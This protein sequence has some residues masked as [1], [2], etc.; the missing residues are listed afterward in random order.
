MNNLTKYYGVDVSKSYLDV[1]GLDKPCRFPNTPEGCAQLFAAL[2][3]HAHLVCEASG[4]YERILCA[5][6]W[7]AARPI[8][9]VG[10][11]RVR[12]FARSLGLL[13]KTDRLDAAL[14]TRYAIERKPVPVGPPDEVI[15]RLRSYLRAREHVLE[16][17]RHE[18]NHREHLADTPLLREQSDTRLKL[19]DGQIDALE[20]AVTE[21]GASKP[22]L[23]VCAARLQE[24]RGVGKITA[25]T[26]CA[27]LP[28]LGE[29]K[30]GQAAAL[31]G[32]APFARDSG[33]RNGRRFI[34]RGRSTLRRVLHMAAITASVHNPRLRE[35]YLH[36][37]KRGKP[38]KVALVALAR[39][40][41]EFLN[42]IVK[43][44]N[45][46]LDI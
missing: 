22:A 27:D 33:D 15:E 30:P 24:V 21:L 8:S 3:P 5:A 42:H 2:P 46:C 12:A 39:R 11:D 23:A 6:A 7:S 38:S 16:L 18:I 20:K 10:A 34:V 43:N 29:L 14:L 37:K 26:I 28:E 41:I 1:D 25:W 40:L 19:L 4:G 45:F 31:C 36:L 32:L 35:V 9:L 13:A 17:R 44:P